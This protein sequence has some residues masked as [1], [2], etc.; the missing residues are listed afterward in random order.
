[1]TSPFAM[2]TGVWLHIASMGVVSM[3]VLPISTAISSSTNLHQAFHTAALALVAVGIGCGLA[4]PYSYETAIHSIG[5][6]ALFL[7]WLGAAL[8]GRFSFKRAHV[9]CSHLVVLVLFPLQL[10]TGL[11]A[12][13]HLADEQRSGAAGSVVALLE[14]IAFFALA[15]GYARM[16]AY[17]GAHVTTPEMMRAYTALMLE[18]GLL[19]LGSVGAGLYSI[20]F[21]SNDTI[22]LVTHVS[23]ATA[24]AIISFAATMAVAHAATR[25]EQVPTAVVRGLPTAIVAMLATVVIVGWPERQSAYLRIGM[26][27]LVLALVSAAVARLLRAMRCMAVPLAVA[28]AVTF[29]CQRGIESMH[30][31]AMVMSELWWLCVTLFGVALGLVVHA[32][33]G[34]GLQFDDANPHDRVILDAMYRPSVA[35]R[36]HRSRRRAQQRSQEEIDE[37]ISSLVDDVNVD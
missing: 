27:V 26:F 1:M 11:V 23:T 5:G 37:D 29:A 21:R 13:L 16:T 3:L 31:E 19:F 8:L 2:S 24:F 15:V 34:T 18:N 36:V 32:C 10:L 4:T 30:N 25:A 35:P 7:I 6:F 9:M 17:V 20:Y 12:A 33:C 28:A 22:R 14:T